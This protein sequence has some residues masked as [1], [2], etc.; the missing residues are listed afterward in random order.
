MFV[1]VTSKGAP[2]VDVGTRVISSTAEFRTLHFY[3][4]FIEHDSLISLIQ[5]QW[6]QDWEIWCDRFQKFWTVKAQVFL[7]IKMWYSSYCSN[8]MWAMVLTVFQQYA[9]YIKCFERLNCCAYV[10]V[11]LKN[12]EGKYIFIYWVWNLQFLSCYVCVCFCVC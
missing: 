7:A 3:E 8:C 9:N 11:P 10:Y 2:A 1:K 4:S 6:D 12:S 5:F